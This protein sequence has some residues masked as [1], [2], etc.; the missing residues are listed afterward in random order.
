MSAFI[1]NGKVHDV[2]V[3]KLPSTGLYVGWF[4][5]T[6]GFGVAFTPEKPTDVGMTLEELVDDWKAEIK[7][8][9][10]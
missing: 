4:D 6:M 1:W 2:T 3:A 10:N 7:K 5:N 8:T 9:L